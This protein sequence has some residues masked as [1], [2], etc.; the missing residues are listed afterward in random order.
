MRWW[1]ISRRNFTWHVALTRTWISEPSLVVWLWGQVTTDSCPL[2]QL[3]QLAFSESCHFDLDIFPAK[4]VI[5]V[6][7]LHYCSRYWHSVG[8]FLQLGSM[9]LFIEMLQGC[10]GPQIGMNPKPK[11]GSLIWNNVEFLRRK[12]SVFGFLGVATVA[13]LYFL[14]R[15]STLFQIGDPHFCLG[16]IPIWGPTDAP[17]LQPLSA[18]TVS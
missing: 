2:L 17:P 15:N 7:L 14:R 11:W 1:I 12:H 3:Q 8:I 6:R 16:F 10:V 5:Y 13:A 4:T 9:Y 18:V